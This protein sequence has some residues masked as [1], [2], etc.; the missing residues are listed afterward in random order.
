M[1]GKPAIL[2]KILKTRAVVI[3]E[4]KS[5]ADLAAIQASVSACETYAAILENASY[6]ID[7]NGHLT[8]Q[9]TQNPAESNPASDAIHEYVD[10]AENE[11]TTAASAYNSIA[12]ADLFLNTDGHLIV[13]YPS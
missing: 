2:P 8:I 11:Q 3:N 1:K 13:D 5:T 4:T 12:N 6:R 7:D 10:R 9:F